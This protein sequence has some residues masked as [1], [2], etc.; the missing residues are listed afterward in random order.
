MF[1]CVFRAV[2]LALL[3]MAAWGLWQETERTVA[4]RFGDW[5]DSY[6]L[7]QG[8]W[9]L[10]PEMAAGRKIHYRFEYKGWQFG[11]SPHADSA[12]IPLLG[13]LGIRRKLVRVVQAN[14]AGRPVRS[15]D[16][17]YAMRPEIMEFTYAPGN[18]LAETICR[19]YNGEGRKGTFEVRFS[20]ADRAGKTNA[21][22]KMLATEDEDLPFF[23]LPANITSAVFN[24]NEL[25]FTDRANIAQFAISR[26]GDGR[27]VE[28]R[29]LDP[30]GN[31][32]CDADGVWGV[33]Y[34]YE[35]H[36]RVA[37]LR[38][39]GKN[40]DAVENSIGV[41]GMDY[42]YGNHSGSI[43]VSKFVDV[44]GRPVRG[45]NG[46]IVC[47]IAARDRF[48]NATCESYLDGNGAADVL[49]YRVSRTDFEYDSRGFTSRIVFYD[50]AGNR[51]PGEQGCAELR[52][53]HDA[54]GNLVHCEKFDVDGNLCANVSGA[55]MIDSVY[56][57]RG[58]II[59]SIYRNADGS[60]AVVSGG[61]SSNRYEYDDAGRR[62]QDVNCDGE[63]NL[64]ASKDGIARTVYIRD[65]CGR[66]ERT[67]SYGS[68]GGRVC[69]SD[70]VWAK[71]YEYDGRGNVVLESFLDTNGVRCVNSSG[72]ATSQSVYDASGRICATVALDADGRR[73]RDRNGACE[74][75]ITFLEP[76]TKL[77][78]MLGVYGE[79]FVTSGG[80]SS[81]LV[82]LDRRGRKISDVYLDATGK[83]LHTSN[84]W[85]RMDYVLDDYGRTV[86]ETKRNSAGIERTRNT[87]NSRGDVVKKENLDAE[88]NVADTESG[89]AVV[90]F[91]VD[92]Y[93][94]TTAMR[95]FKADGAKAE[96]N[97][98]HEML[99]TLDNRGNAV[100]IVER[101][102]N[103]ESCYPYAIA[104]IE[105]D[106]FDRM[107]RQLF[108]DADG[109]PARN[110]DGAF[111]I[112]YS[113]GDDGLVASWV[114]L[115]PD[116]EAANL[117]DRGLAELRKRY[118]AAGQCVWEEY[119]A[120]DGAEAIDSQ[121]GAHA[122]ETAYDGQGRES[123]IRIWG[124]NGGKA[125]IGGVWRV[126]SEYG[127]NGEIL[128]KRYFDVDGN[129][130]KEETPGAEQPQQEEPA[131][132]LEN[133][134]KDDKP[135]APSPWR[136]IRDDK[137]GESVSEYRPPDGNGELADSPEGYARSVKTFDERGN[138]VCEKHYARDGKMLKCNPEADFYFVRS[139]FDSSGFE[140]KRMYFGEDG[141][142]ARRSDGTFGTAVSRLEGE[143]CF[144]RAFIDADGNV[145]EDDK[146]VARTRCRFDENGN[147]V[148]T[149]Y[150]DAA[151]NR[152]LHADGNHGWRAT[153]DKAGRETSIEYFGEDG[154]RV[155]IE[156]GYSRRE[157]E[158]Y[159]SGRIKM[160]KLFDADG[161]PVSVIGWASRKFEY[162]AAGNILREIWY[163]PDGS[164]ALRD[165]KNG[166]AYWESEYDS[167]G[168]ETLRMF[169]GPDRKGV[170]RKEGGV[171]G[172][173]KVY[174]AKGRVART[175]FVDCDMVRMNCNEGF[176]ELVFTYDEA[177]EISNIRKI[178]ARGAEIGN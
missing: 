14:S 164:I 49:R 136:T 22:V 34:E 118:N 40:G 105:P 50:A 26:N 166:V 97:G 20:F 106:R 21:F 31:P 91:E 151:G 11:A 158:Y 57:D 67:E 48:D 169:F 135:E 177:G 98:V 41:A 143:R 53:V 58:N 30:A 137:T 138:V 170:L 109:N 100:S 112:R 54:Q 156:D 94:R 153:Y 52:L 9:P 163:A 171:G 44:D 122:V 85:E 157:K 51:T 61:F 128:V 115:G 65:D 69:S 19:R 161:K 119:F 32:E 113:Y 18:R 43:D 13:K 101:K 83:E 123:D 89:F 64:A 104:L 117:P 127:D 10:S 25:D 56:D 71:C 146:G 6:G 93:G 73:A 42:E 84:C 173:K 37:S 103:G 114:Y 174:D 78:R 141:L 107:S 72:V 8:L 167:E 28:I 175:I 63:G 96:C 131:P 149:A 77:V 132:P 81:V 121:S 7:P 129:I 88:G 60:A 147:L 125:T 139:T 92:S 3:A 45:A 162:D 86:E 120:S 23:Y 99:Y 111:G 62:T 126:A 82:S 108:R 4:V 27:A 79:P 152:A 68:D 116:G 46:A 159:K 70:G 134:K 150:Y 148:E 24:P 35:K 155:L 75:A 95:F 124:L 15:L 66:I 145:M 110:K 154:E 165:A 33:R 178:D 55:C 90:E 144:E 47:K 172:I 168:R 5:V 17:D 87:Y 102:A 38:Y 176:C 76:K 74:L 16:T 130:V 12:P 80:W 59:E 142:P 2:A 1:G 140:T 29:Y 36:G 160:E 133:V 39:L